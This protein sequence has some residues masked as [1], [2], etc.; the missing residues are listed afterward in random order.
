MTVL[1]M[2][3]HHLS[4]ADIGSFMLLQCLGDI[5]ADFSIISRSADGVHEKCERT[6]LKTLFRFSFFGLFFAAQIVQIGRKR[7]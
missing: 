2:K 5:L 6:I 3:Q 1:D 4:S 7:C